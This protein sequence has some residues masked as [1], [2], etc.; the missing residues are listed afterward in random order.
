MT[1][2]NTTDQPDT[3]T[4][5]ETPAPEREVEAPEPANREAARYRRQL[6]DTEAKAAALSERVEAMQ[7]REVERLAA[8]EMTTPADLWLTGTE[9]AGLLDDDGDVDAAKVKAA[10][11]TV[12]EERPGWRLTSVPSFDGGIRTP[13]PTGGADWQAVLRG[14]RV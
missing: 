6:R 10:V 11:G 3:T 7:R 9:L 4:T 14:H 1:T 2:E 12:L 8:S 5:T 13:A